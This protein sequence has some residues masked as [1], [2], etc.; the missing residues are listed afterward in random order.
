M[1]R[2]DLAINKNTTGIL[3]IPHIRQENAGMRNVYSSIPQLQ[4]PR[5]TVNWYGVGKMN[6]MGNTLY[7]GSLQSEISTA[8]TEKDYGGSKSMIFPFGSAEVKKPLENSG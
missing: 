7:I 3:N 1:K 2:L 8:F 5:R 6:C 4:Q